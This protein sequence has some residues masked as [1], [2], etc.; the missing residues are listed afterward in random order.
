MGGTAA[1]GEDYLCTDTGKTRCVNV[2][3]DRGVFPYA[4]SGAAMG[5][6]NGTVLLDKA[7]A[8]GTYYRRNR[9]YDP[10]TARFTQE[11]PIGLSGG[12]NAYGFASG[13]PVNFGDPFGL[14]K[15]RTGEERPCRVTWSAADNPDERVD[16]R[17]IAHIQAIADLAD[18]DLV[19]SSG[20]RGS[21]PTSNHFRG[22]AVDIKT[23]NGV[24]IGQGKYSNP[25]AMALVERVQGAA[26]NVPG[27]R[28]NFGPWRLYKSL[29]PGMF[30]PFG[31]G[32]ALESQ[33]QNHVHVSIQP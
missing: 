32:T 15:T 29:K 27:T 30:A 20:R 13:D 4:R 12:I 21:N 10:S 25:A 16:P 31:Y 3:L 5:S 8:A 14:C 33:H 23:I 24:D 18:V 19:L 11:D 9:T 7:D 26:I 1:P 2:Y 28:E 22:L 17:L 6:W